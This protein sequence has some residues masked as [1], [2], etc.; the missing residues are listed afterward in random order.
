[1]SLALMGH[2][3]Y[4]VFAYDSC[5]ATPPSLEEYC[6]PACYGRFSEHSSLAEGMCLRMTSSEFGYQAWV[7]IQS[8]ECSPGVLERLAGSA[9]FPERR[10]GATIVSCVGHDQASLLYIAA[11]EIADAQAQIDYYLGLLPAEP[12]SLGNGRRDRV[13]LLSL[14]DSSTRWLRPKN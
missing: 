5:N 9:Y 10:M 12:G 7:F 11:P 1:M 2:C 13:Q 14:G 6:A 8:R 4:C 3:H